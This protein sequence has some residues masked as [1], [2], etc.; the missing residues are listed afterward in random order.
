M[1]TNQYYFNHLIALHTVKTKKSDYVGN[2]TY[3]ENIY[4]KILTTSIKV[5]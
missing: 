2:Y 5:R 1:V 3:K 4:H